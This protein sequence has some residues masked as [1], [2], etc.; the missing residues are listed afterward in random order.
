M[1]EKKSFN[2]KKKVGRILYSRKVLLN[3]KINL[4]QEHKLSQDDQT[5]FPE[6]V[7]QMN[8]K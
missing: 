6:K 2:I 1:T 5:P 7:K 4:R 8:I 3:A